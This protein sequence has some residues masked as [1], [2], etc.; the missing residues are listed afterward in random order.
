MEAILALLGDIQCRSLQHRRGLHKPKL[1]VTHGT[2]SCSFKVDM[3]P[4]KASIHALCI[5]RL[6]RT[7]VEKKTAARYF[8][9]T[10]VTLLE[11]FEHVFL[12][13]LPKRHAVE[14]YIPL[15]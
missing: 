5:G 12:P 15:Q 1:R 8:R 2:S 10:F 4:E 13:G 3:E 11:Q 14:L 7:K 6:R 9:L